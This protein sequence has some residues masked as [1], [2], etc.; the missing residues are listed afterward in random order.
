MKPHHK[1]PRSRVIRR[2]LIAIL[3][4][5]WVVADAIWWVAARGVIPGFYLLELNPHMQ[6]SYFFRVDREPP[7]MVAQDDP[8]VELRLRTDATLRREDIVEMHANISGHLHGG[9]WGRTRRSRAMSLTFT[10]F[11]G[12]DRLDSVPGQRI[13][14]AVREQTLAYIRANKPELIPLVPEHLAEAPIGDVVFRASAHDDVPN[15]GG[16]VHNAVSS[17]VFA[18]FLW[19]VWPRRRQSLTPPDQSTSSAS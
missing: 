15:W 8:S 11:S 7:S 2:R 12:K 16:Y 3:C 17:A 5:L 10:D 1:S 13:M 6:F 9:L 19:A 14:E 4:G 18:G